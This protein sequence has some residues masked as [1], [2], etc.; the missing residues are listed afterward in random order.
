MSE[1]VT[2]YKGSPTTISITPSGPNPPLSLEE[3]IKNLQQHHQVKIAALEALLI[4]KLCPQ[5]ASVIQHAT[6]KGEVDKSE[7]NTKSG[8]NSKTPVLAATTT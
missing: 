6:E 8:T 1:E 7:K 2:S 3:H 4:N 5:Q